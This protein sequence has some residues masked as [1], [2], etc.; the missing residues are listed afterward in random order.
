M[1]PADDNLKRYLLFED[2]NFFRYDFDK[3]LDSSLYDLILGGKSYL[4]IVTWKDSEGCIKG[5]SFI[6]LGAVNAKEHKECVYYKSTLYNGEKV[7]YKIQKKNLIIL[8]L[9]EIGFR[10][11]YFRRLLKK[12]VEIDLPSDSM[13]ENGQKIGFDF[14][15]FNRRNELK[16]LYINRKTH[17][18]GRNY[19]NQHLSES[20]SLYRTAKYKILRLSILDYFFKQF[21]N[22]LKR[23]QEECDF[24]GEIIATFERISYE[25]HLESLQKGEINT[26]QF[27]DI[28]YPKYV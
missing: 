18:L 26:S 25:E 2:Y 10:R 28:I 14:L 8:D 27:C 23:F 13:I 19:N 9:K 21:N 17:W 15:E 1:R 5:I 6:P 4:E 3:I 24:K 20:Y 12:M 22:A 16:L 11:N 7:K